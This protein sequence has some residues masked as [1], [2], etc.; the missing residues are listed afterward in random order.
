MVYRLVD[1]GEVCDGGGYYIV[2]Y[3]GIGGGDCG[4]GEYKYKPESIIITG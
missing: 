3:W 1:S 2:C 4:A